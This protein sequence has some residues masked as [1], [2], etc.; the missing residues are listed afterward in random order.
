MADLW[1]RSWGNYKFTGRLLRGDIAWI[2]IA[3]S[4]I[5]GSLG[6]MVIEEYGLIEAFYMAVIAFST[7]GFTE[8]RPL[9]P[10]GRIF[11]SFLIIFNIGVFAY[12]L[13]VFTYYVV[14]GEFFKNLH[15]KHIQ[16]K[17]DSLQDHVILCGYG[18][19]GKEVAKTFLKHKLPFVVIEMDHEIIREIQSNDL[20]MLYIEGNATEDEILK[21]AGIM[22]AKS[23]ITTLPDDSENLFIVLSADQLKPELNIV[24]R[25][26]SRHAEKKMRLAGADHVIL[27]DQIGSFYMATLVNKPETVEFFSFLTNEFESDVG[28]EEIHYRQMPEAC[29]NQSIADLNIRNVSGANII[30]YKTP[31]GRYLVNPPP[32]TKLIKDSSFILLGDKEQLTKLR[33]YL[34]NYGEQDQP[35]VSD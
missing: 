30:G 23:L 5:G 4:L 1:Q 6:Y 28:F 19:Y 27:P 24:S 7:V 8:V 10:E 11:T 3:I 14:Q 26:I 31:G 32:N 20:E 29:H 9:S 33:A 15:L 2:L 17:I 35:L 21:K 22:R 25:G 18:R 13:S 16:S 34:D 12:F